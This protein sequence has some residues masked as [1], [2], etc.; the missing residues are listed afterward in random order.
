MYCGTRGAI[1]PH[2]KCNKGAVRPDINVVARL[3]SDT[4]ISRPG[5]VAPSHHSRL[6]SNYSYSY[7]A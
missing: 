3:R 6:P 7:K 5:K 1:E 4:S 2:W